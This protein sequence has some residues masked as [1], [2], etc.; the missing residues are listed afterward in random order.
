MGK[1][2]PIRIRRSFRVV[3]LIV[4]EYDLEHPIRNLR[5]IGGLPG[6]RAAIRRAVAVLNA[7]EVSVG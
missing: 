6:N 4:I 3:P 7:L 1:D 2:A 5:W